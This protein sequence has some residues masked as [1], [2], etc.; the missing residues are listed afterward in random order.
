M[1]T[2][3]YNEYMITITLIVNVIGYNCHYILSNHD[4]SHESGFTD[5]TPG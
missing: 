5:L 2:S 4:Y 3:E 1:N